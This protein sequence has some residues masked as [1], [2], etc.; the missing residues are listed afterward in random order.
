M[1]TKVIL[2]EV[3]FALVYVVADILPQLTDSL[4]NKFCE[5][6]DYIRLWAYTI[7]AFCSYFALWLRTYAVFYRKEVVKQF[8]KKW[9][10]FVHILSLVLLVIYFISLL[11]IFWPFF[12]HIAAD[13]SCR[14]LDNSKS[15]LAMIMFLWIYNIA[16]V[17]L[18]QALFLFSFIYPLYLHKKKMHQRGF[19]EIK[20]TIPIMK[21]ATIVAVVLIASDLLVVGFAVVFQTPN[22]RFQH[23][24]ASINLLVNAIS[25]NMCFANW[26]ERL[27]PYTLKCKSKELQ[28]LDT[29]AV[30]QNSDNSENQ[31]N[32]Q[33]T[34]TSITMH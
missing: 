33:S 17:L 11:L 8:V 28:N 29:H 21:R 5:I 15:Y 12:I 18:L 23:F 22:V 6:R 30:K 26:R 7:A 13:C 9:V 2:V 27:F 1:I 34:H 3:M 10:R 14:I 20:S 4:G 19:D 32:V 16:A 25:T 31:N 24:S